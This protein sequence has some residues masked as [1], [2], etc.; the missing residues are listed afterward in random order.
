MIIPYLATIH[1]L[2]GG[3]I[4]LSTGRRTVDAAGNLGPSDKNG[5]AWRIYEQTEVI[6]A[7]GKAPVLSPT[8]RPIAQTVC[9]MTT[10]FP[11]HEHDYDGKN[12]ASAY[13]RD[14]DNGSIMLG[15]IEFRYG[16]DAAT[17]T[18]WGDRLVEGCRVPEADTVYVADQYG[19]LSP[20]SNT[21]FAFIRDNFKLVAE[22][23][24]TINDPSDPKKPPLFDLKLLLRGLNDQDFPR[25]RSLCC[26]ITIT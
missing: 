24:W 17:S 12:G 8:A 9:G 2:H 1:Q 23:Y 22:T 16:Q 10:F 21:P 18:S 11:G 25:P 13:K 3:S 7:P 14:R 15:K 19:V 4:D 20:P 6:T 5:H 26:A